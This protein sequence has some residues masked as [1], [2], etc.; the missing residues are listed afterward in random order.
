MLPIVKELQDIA[1]KQNL[2]LAPENFFS[3][4]SL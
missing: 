3:L 1:N 4:L 2:K